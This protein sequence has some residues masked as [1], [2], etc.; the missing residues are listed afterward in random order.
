MKTAKD[1]IIEAFI[2]LLA[3]NKFEDLYVKDIARQ[4]NVSR[5]T[6]YLHFIDK[7]QLMEE[8]R[9]QLNDQFLSFYTE[10]PKMKPVTLEICRHIFT[11][12]SFYSREFSDAVAMHHLSNRLAFRLLDIF[13][14]QDYAIFA[15][16]GTI[17]YLSSWVTG[18]FQVS[19]G[20]A[21][22]K[23]MKIGFTNWTEMISADVH[24]ENLSQ[25][26]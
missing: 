22:E 7:F 19:P 25:T 17:G 24:R 21:A 11:F 6:F 1:L 18:G 10:P 16:S 23:L 2:E 9:G 15:S 3:V 4:A 12:R 26:N 14:D 5:S 13:H 8:V 20:E